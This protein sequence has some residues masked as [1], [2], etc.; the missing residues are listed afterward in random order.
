MRLLTASCFVL[1]VACG[2]GVPANRGSAAAT[3]DAVAQLAQSG[4]SC[5]PDAPPD[6]IAACSG[7]TAGDTC[8]VT[9][10][11]H[12]FSGTC[13]ATPKGD[14]AC[15]PPAAPPPPPPAVA[16]CAGKSAGDACQ[17]SGDGNS[18]DGTCKAFGTGAVACVPNP[19]PPPVSACAGKAAGDTCTL[20]EDDDGDEPVTGICR[21]DDG[22][23]VC[24]PPL[25]ASPPGPPPGPRTDACT[26]KTAGAACS[27][28]DGE[29]TLGGV[30]HLLPH[31]LACLPPNPPEEA[32]AACA[33][34]A[35]GDTCA[36]SWKDH[37]LSGA[38]RTEPDETTL[39]C[40]P[41]CPP[42]H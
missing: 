10:E 4:V 13:A 20:S 22:A 42:E 39:V 28:P 33:G 3:A 1:L 6:A 8:A 25:P 38:C 36:F 37:T 29:K 34:K 2:G 9:H 11:E 32:A 40:A 30:C 24:R 21:D 14:L 27:F 12:G 17:L 41:L 15:R 23:L 7:K 5:E 18:R 19:P 26:G 35:S 31:G 16:A